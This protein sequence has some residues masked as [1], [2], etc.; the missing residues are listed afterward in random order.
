MGNIFAWQETEDK[1][2]R[3]QTGAHSWGRVFQRAYNIPPDQ[4]DDQL[5]VR[6]DL[7]LGQT[8]LT[9]A[10]VLNWHWGQSRQG[11][12]QL[13]VE[14]AQAV[15]FTDA[16]SD[17]LELRGSRVTSEDGKYK[18]GTRI[19]AATADTKAD[20]ISTLFTNAAGTADTDT[21]LARRKGRVTK[22]DQVLPG[23]WLLTAQYVGFEDHELLFLRDYDANTLQGPRGTQVFVELASNITTKCTGLL[24]TYFPGTSPRMPCFS[25]KANWNPFGIAGIALI[26]ARFGIPVIRYQRRL[27]YM[28]L[29]AKVMS[30]SRRKITRDLD[31][32]VIEGWDGTELWSIVP[33]SKTGRTGSNYVDDTVVFLKIET[34]VLDKSGLLADAIALKNH[35]NKDTF[36]LAQYGRVRK[37]TFRS[38]G[39]EILTAYE[40][41]ITP[42]NYFIEV[43][44]AGWNNLLKSQKSRLKLIEVP[45]YNSAGT[46]VGRDRDTTQVIPATDA[47]GNAA[48]VK[49]RQIYPETNFSRFMRGL[50]KWKIA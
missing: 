40:A 45:V 34:A 46:K 16:T 48:P 21:R 49:D 31:N 29:S 5:P 17:P 27:G 42:V 41:K 47:D 35:I 30:R 25:A 22:N 23:V 20:D 18:Y 11:P 33:H 10:R 26:R 50:K 24:K 15:A 1:T 37:G 6:G 39:T 28:K 2:K 8:G 4:G 7:M 43:E 38:V 32:E 3:R 36:T 13:I 44:P 19:Y 14:W 9:A 12:I